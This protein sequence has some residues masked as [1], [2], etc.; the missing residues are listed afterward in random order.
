MNLDIK[1]VCNNVMIIVPHQDDEIL[2][3]SGVI[4]ICQKNN[5]P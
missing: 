2:M 1:K 3:A 4:R 5:I